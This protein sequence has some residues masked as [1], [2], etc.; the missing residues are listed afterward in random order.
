M[1]CNKSP[2]VAGET[3]SNDPNL[4]K[5]HNGIATL[6]LLYIRCSSSL[7]INYHTSL[8]FLFPIIN[9]FIN[10]NDLVTIDSCRLHVRRS[11]YS[12]YLSFTAQFCSLPFA[13]LPLFQSVVTT[14]FSKTQSVVFAISSIFSL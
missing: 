13:L 11:T 6:H 4:Q 14:R 10:V 8:S 1:T 2:S 9:S 7:K 3:L 5:I 12:L